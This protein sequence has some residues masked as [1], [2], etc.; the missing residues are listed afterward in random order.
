MAHQAAD[1]A[2]HAALQQLKVV[3][4]LLTHGMPMAAYEEKCSLLQATTAPDISR[5]GWSDATGWR[6]AQGERGGLRWVH[7]MMR[8]VQHADLGAWDF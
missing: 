3:F 4:H 2:E 1:A 8:T 5:K 6:H 7:L